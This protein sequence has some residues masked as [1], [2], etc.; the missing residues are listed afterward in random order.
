[1][2]SRQGPHQDRRPSQ[3]HLPPSHRKACPVPSSGRARGLSSGGPPTLPTSRGRRSGTTWRRASQHVSLRRSPREERLALKSS[4]PRLPKSFKK[5][6]P[7][8]A[9][10]A[11]LAQ[12]PIQARMAGYASASTFQ[13]SIG[14]HLRSFSG[15]RAWDAARVRLT[16]RF[17]RPL[18]CRA[19]CPPSSATCGASWR[20]RRPDITQSW[21]RWRWP[22]GSRQDPQSLPRLRAPVAREEQ[23]LHRVPS[24]AP[25]LLRQQN[26][27]TFSKFI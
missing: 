5:Q 2:A 26:Q 14:P 3:G 25:T 21:W 20:L 12:L 15:L 6:E 13:G 16:A 11:H 9:T 27:M 22:S 24:A 23:F 1:M 18:P 7:C 4:S 19:W 10:A 17:A 8:A